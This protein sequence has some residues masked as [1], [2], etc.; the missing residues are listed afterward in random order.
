MKILIT[1]ANGLVGQHLIKLLLD[2]ADATIIAAGRGKNR[3]PFT[4]DERFTY[5][6]VDITDGVA[7]TAFYTE[8]RPDVVVHAAAMTQ[9]DDCED[10]KVACWNINV[11]ATRFL[12]EAVKPFNPYLIFL[13]TDFVFDGLHGPYSETAETGP[14]NYYGSSKVAAEKDILQSGLN[15]AVVRTC[16]VYG[17]ALKGT[18]PNI[19]NWVKNNL[20]AGKKN[21]GSCRSVANANF[22]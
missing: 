11:T 2:K 5:F 4:V 17:N 8:Q 10:D 15:A 16:L 3:L 14:V 22:Y 1:G 19:V 21:K 12:I 6:D 18:R 7:A 13:S 9:A 20:Q